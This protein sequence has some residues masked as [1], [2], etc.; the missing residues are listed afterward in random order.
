[1]S[2]LIKKS[3]NSK[4]STVYLAARTLLVLVLPI[5]L[6]SVSFG[7]ASKRA[8]KVMPSN[9]TESSSVGDASVW[10]MRSDGAKQCMP[11]SGVTLVQGSADLQAS[12][13]GVLDSK[14]G[15]DGKMHA[16][17]CGSSRGSTNNYLIGRDKLDQALALGYSEVVSSR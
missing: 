10:I 2:T 16:Q 3:L 6:V 4:L 1:M 7:F 11:G 8:E 15:T 9:N 5:F 13:I 14:K 12:N 17:V